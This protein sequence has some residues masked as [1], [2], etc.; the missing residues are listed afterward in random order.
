MVCLYSI[1]LSLHRFHSGCLPGN[2]V[3]RLL[4]VHFYLMRTCTC[5]KSAFVSNSERE[6]EYENV[7]CLL[8]LK[9][10]EIKR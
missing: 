2:P 4:S 9:E 8:H 10:P 7:K 3:A 1:L 5:T 6:V